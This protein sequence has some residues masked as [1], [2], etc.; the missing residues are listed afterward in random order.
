MKSREEKSNG[1]L[2]TR[3]LRLIALLAAFCFAVLS[4]SA[5]LHGDEGSRRSLASSSTA[6][7]SSVQQSDGT[8]AP[9][10]TA[11]E[12]SHAYTCPLCDWLNTAS[13]SFVVPPVEIAIA[14]SVIA[15]LLLFVRFAALCSRPLPRRG[16]RAP[17][18]L[19]VTQGIPQAA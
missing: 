10:V 6:S 19:F 15:L 12:V 3:A 18:R 5:S 16:L 2:R 1:G 11:T 9:F 4:V 14:V 17:P 8:I 7:A 13:T